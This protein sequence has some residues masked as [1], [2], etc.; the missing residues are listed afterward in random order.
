MF[1]ASWLQQDS[2]LQD[3]TFRLS[4]VFICCPSETIAKVTGQ[5]EVKFFI[6]A[7]L[8]LSAALIVTIYD[9]L[10]SLCFVLLLY[11]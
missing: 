5:H 11:N 1:V 6:I 2:T 3:P 7:H 4:Y 9:W 8:N 10:D